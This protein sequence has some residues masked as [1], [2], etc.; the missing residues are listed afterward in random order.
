MSKRLQWVPAARRYRAE[1]SQ[2]RD[3]T[4]APDFPLRGQLDAEAR[5]D[6]VAPQMPEQPEEEL[7]DPLF[8]DPLNPQPR[9][10][11]RTAFN[12]L[13]TASKSKAEAARMKRKV[14]D[15]LDWEQLRKETLATYT[16]QKNIPVVSK[17]VDDVEREPEVVTLTER[18]RRRLEG[19]EEEDEEA[20]GT[21]KNMTQRELVAHL[22]SL[23]DDLENAWGKGE[24]VKSLRIVIQSCKLLISC[25]VPQVYPSLFMLVAKVLDTFGRLVF[26]R[27]KRRAQFDERTGR[28]IQTLPAEFHTADIPDEAK[29]MC[30]N[31]FFKVAAIREL[32]PR[33]YVELCLWECHRFL[34]DERRAYVE[35][36]GRFVA[37][38]RGMGDPLVANYARV[39]LLHRAAGIFHGDIPAEY[40]VQCFEDW[41]FTR[42]QWQYPHFQGYLEGSGQTMEEYLH[43]YAPSLG[44]E[45]SWL[46]VGADENR[47]EATL[48]V[49]EKSG[50]LLVLQHLI[51]AFS[52]Q[53]IAR[54]APRL[55]QCIKSLGGAMAARL[56]CYMALGVQL[57]REPPPAKLRLQVLND[58][59]A[60]VAEVRDPDRY[61]PVAHAWLEFVARHLSHRETGILIN[62][63]MAHVG[64]DAFTEGLEAHVQGLLCVLLDHVTDFHVLLSL[65]PLLPLID[66]LKPDSKVD[67]CKTLLTNFTQLGPTVTDPVLV[68]A[69]LDLCRTIHD[70]LTEF[71]VE[72]DRR[73]FAQLICCVLPKVSFGVDLD[74]HLAFF[75]EC[76]RSFSKL[77]AVIEACVMG[78]LRLVSRSLRLSPVK[79]HS[80]RA[81][82]FVKACL[83][84][85][86]IT[87]PALADPFQR[88]RL[89]LLAA[90]VA[91]G[92]GFAQQAD[93]L[94]QTVLTL[95]RE[96][97]ACIL[98]SS[99]PLLGDCLLQL[100]AALVAVPGHPQEGPLYWLAALMTVVQEYPWDAASPVK[101]QVYIA[102]LRALSAL[103]QE[104]LPYHFG[105]GGVP[106]ND[107][108]YAGSEVYRPAVEG[109]ATTFL[110]ALLTDIAALADGDRVAAQRAAELAAELLITVVAFA[111]PTDRMRSLASKLWAVAAKQ[112]VANGRQLATIRA[113]IQRSVA[114]AP[115]AGHLT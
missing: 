4:V 39:Y 106:S 111:E 99:E 105:A 20:K 34:V 77:D 95:L 70:A 2:S 87:L 84:Y 98:P 47:F 5:A 14:D 112:P 26:E 29:E 67:L 60:D 40:R 50:L 72:D 28:P 110:D 1:L 24:K 33:V 100:L 75:V 17:I 108:L 23:A 79:Q 113:R 7:A 21:K 65:D 66:L 10:V 37:Q 94:L 61:L 41:N 107:E 48:V 90:M 96:V 93:T 56:A 85:C 46:A 12:T 62:D 81:A 30:K 92:A 15:V 36:M 6:G 78:V 73:Q 51:A 54:H 82:A 57:A 97:P 102:S 19:L 104:E 88:L 59:W 80:K 8:D 76:R 35:M 31:W 9:G 86:H 53:L 52:P 83:A 109:L 101:G 27:I 22:E 74:A 38:M 103:A 69:L 16:T 32:I 55:V 114:W 89:L 58:V 115:L 45:L 63:I 42:R 64:P 3:A 49:V 71:S 13:A 43:L 11:R 25:P 44:W 91:F 18:A 68:H